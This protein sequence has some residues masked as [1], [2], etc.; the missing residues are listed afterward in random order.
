MTCVITVK[1]THDISIKTYFLQ[2]YREE[3]VIQGR[4][5]LCNIKCYNTSMTLLEPPCMNEVSEI[6]T[7]ISS[8]LLSNTAVMPLE[9]FLWKCSMGYKL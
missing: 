6:D 1:E 5:E 4:K 7:N 3:R 2:A 8:G 9:N